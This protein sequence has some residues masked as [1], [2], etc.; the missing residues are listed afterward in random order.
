MAKEF[1][2]R[3]INLNDDVNDDIGDLED[4]EPDELVE[5]EGD[6]EIPEEGEDSPGEKLPIEEE[7]DSEEE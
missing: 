7:L 2:T 4:D 6:E 5:T 1:L 3:F